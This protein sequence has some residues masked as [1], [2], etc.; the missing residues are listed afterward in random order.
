[1]HTIEAQRREEIVY[2]GRMLHQYGFVAATDGN[3]SARLPDG[4]IVA[5]P[6]SISKG[7]MRPEDL[8]V[9][10]P[11]GHRLSGCRNVSSEIGMH[12]LIYRMRPDVNGIVHAHPP[13]A[14][15]FAAAGLPLDQPI[16]CEVILS[17]GAVP[18]A[19]YATPG[20]PGLAESLVPLV[21]DYDAVLMANHGVVTYGETLLKA[22][23]NMEIV[24]HFAKIVLV[25][26]QLG[27]QQPLSRLELDR[28]VAV[29]A[30]YE[31]HTSQ[32]SMPPRKEVS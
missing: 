22:Y 27:K 12:L 19:R 26:Q 24:E 25:T 18:V 8:V 16:V 30:S 31:G 5:T 14:T 29:R 17:L 11:E 4:S 20:S 9:V 21:P 23:M 15:G 6:T 32:A 1:M 7:M 10:D 13:T 3:L 28:L 2:F